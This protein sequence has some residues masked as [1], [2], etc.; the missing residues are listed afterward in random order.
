ML[1]EF[2]QRG[3]HFQYC[4]IVLAAVCFAAAENICPDGEQLCA[5]GC[6]SIEHKCSKC[7]LLHFSVGCTAL[8]LE[9]L[10]NWAL[11]HFFFFSSAC[12]CSFSLSLLFSERQLCPY[13]LIECKDRRKCYDKEQEC[14]KVFDCLDRSDELGCGEHFA[15]SLFRV[16]SFDGTTA[17]PPPQPQVTM[18]RCIFS[19]SDNTQSLLLQPQQNSGHRP[20]GKEVLALALARDS[21]HCRRGT[22]TDGPSDMSVCVLDSQV[23][24]LTRPDSL[25]R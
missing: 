25:R 11:W 21:A 15:S 13:P 5:E 16:C 20:R 7:F 14:D 19:R 9:F 6:V 3:Q 22:H 17:A 10:I 24:S 23:S 12:V 1:P 18:S 2:S 8:C 4:Q